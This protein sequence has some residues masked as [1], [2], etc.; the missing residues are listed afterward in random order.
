ML[1]KN[2][3]LC[4]SLCKRVQLVCNFFDTFEQQSDRFVDRDNYKRRGFLLNI[5]SLRQVSL[6]AQS[7]A[8]T[9]TSAGCLDH[10][11]STRSAR[12]H[13]LIRGSAWRALPGRKKKLRKK[14]RKKERKRRSR[15]FHGDFRTARAPLNK[16]CSEL[17]GLAGISALIHLLS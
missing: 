1:C 8:T 10:A 4:Q 11:I 3:Y 17:I 6:P 2:H 13:S 16:L 5:Y 15:H 14:E 12:I 7:K 9:S